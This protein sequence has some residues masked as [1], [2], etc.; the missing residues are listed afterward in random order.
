MS[1][2]GGAWMPFVNEFQIG[3]DCHTCTTVKF[4]SKSQKMHK[5]CKLS[6][7][8]NSSSYRSSR[9][10]WTCNTVFTVTVSEHEQQKHSSAGHEVREK[11][12]E[13][14][15]AKRL[16]RTAKKCNSNSQGNVEQE[17]T[18]SNKRI[19]IR[20]KKETESAVQLACESMKGFSRH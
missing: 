6:T 5:R 7:G 16:D 2:H 1:N 19:T 18:M 20:E 9:S 8:F 13:H 10:D 11:A 4:S 14:C 15:M 3:I 12:Q 17:I